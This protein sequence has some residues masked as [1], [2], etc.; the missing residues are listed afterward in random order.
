MDQALNGDTEP[1]GF[2]AA[3]RAGHEN[4]GIQRVIQ[5]GKTELCVKVDSERD[6]GRARR[7]VAVRQLVLHVSK[8][9]KVPIWPFDIHD[10][11]ARVHSDERRFIQAQPDLNFA[12]EPLDLLQL[13][14]PP[15]ADGK[16]IENRPCH[17]VTRQLYRPAVF[18]ENFSQSP[19]E[20]AC[21]SIGFVLWRRQR[22]GG[23]GGYSSQMSDQGKKLFLRRQD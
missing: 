11:P 15:W 4:V 8:T 18:T 16:T 10:G 17:G 21:R 14:P 3:G 19:A 22:L 1:L 6:K 2:T 23:F 5:I 7:R 13:D 12:G 9:Y 20:R